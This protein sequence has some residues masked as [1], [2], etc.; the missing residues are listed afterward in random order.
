MLVGRRPYHAVR[1]YPPHSSTERPKNATASTPNVLNY[2]K[3]NFHEP[4]TKQMPI[5]SVHKFEDRS[6]LQADWAMGGLVPNGGA[7]ILAN[8]TFSQPSCRVQSE[9]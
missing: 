5:K 1:K 4:A 6:V 9:L 3:R 7:P 2:Q 8:K